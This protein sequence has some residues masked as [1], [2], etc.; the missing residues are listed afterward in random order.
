MISMKENPKYYWGKKYQQQVIFVP[1]RTFLHPCID[2]FVV[3][4]F[5]DTLR[6]VS[7]K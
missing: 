2:V 1:A 4:V 7:L 5:Q 6:G 3:N